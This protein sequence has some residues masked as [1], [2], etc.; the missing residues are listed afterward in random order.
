MIAAVENYKTLK[1]SLAHLI[2]ISGYRNDYVAKKIGMRPPH[3]S[4]KKTKGNWTEEEVE[5]IVA[6]L[7]HVNEEVND[8]ILSEIMDKRLNDKDKEPVMT[9]DE[10]K[11]ELKKIFGKE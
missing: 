11:T 8:F 6:V 4:V 9:Y 10:Y 5:K 1:A 2:D 7:T 3:F